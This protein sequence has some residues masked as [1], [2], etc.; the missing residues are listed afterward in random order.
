[1]SHRHITQLAGATPG[2]R[3]IIYRLAVSRLVKFAIVTAGVLSG[4]FVLAVV[5]TMMFVFS[6]GTATVTMKVTATVFDHQQGK[7]VAGC[8][9]AFE[10]GFDGRTGYGRTSACTD[11][12]G[13]STHESTHSYGGSMFWPFDRDRRPTLRFYIGEPPTYTRKG[14]VET[15][16]LHLQVREP[17]F[18]NGPVT[19]TVNVERAMSRDTSYVF[20][21]GDPVREAI[22]SNPI[23]TDSAAELAKATVTFDRD[24][25]RPVYRI[26]LS[27]YLNTQQ[28]ATCQASSVGK[29][30]SATR[31]QPGNRAAP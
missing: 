20:K 22:E 1:M 10:K 26:P 31:A 3:A 15:W 25:Q 7:P 13:Q 17:W 23:Q 14:E 28:I 21:E 5:G 16:D 9:L 2:D 11:A 12:S 6:I 27:I 8:L 29:T 18:A 30:S 24:E 19:T 4:L